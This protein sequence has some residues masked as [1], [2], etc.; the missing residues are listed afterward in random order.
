MA[1]YGRHL[2]ICVGQYCDPDGVAPRLYAQLA[3]LLGELGNYDNPARVKRGISPCLGVCAGG[4][5][6]VVY[7]E[8][9]WYHHVDE[10]VLARIVKEHLG[11]GRV[12]EEYVFHR[13]RA[14]GPAAGAGG[15]TP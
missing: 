14:P 3:R 12:V 9:I 5:L 8:G 10:A 4:P 6:V 15:A 13:L 11:E 2:L 7:P 1:P